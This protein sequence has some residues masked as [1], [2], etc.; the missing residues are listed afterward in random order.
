MVKIKNIYGDVCTGRKD[1]AVYQ[2][3]YGQAMRRVY[4]DNKPPASPLQ[5][6]QR[7]KFK[8]G[9]AYA[10]SLNKAERD[11]I[12][13]YMKEKNIGWKD[14]DPIHWYN[15]AKSIAMKQPEY[16]VLDSVTGRYRFSHPAILK[17]EELDIDGNVL[18]SMDDL[19]NIMDGRFQ[20]QWMQT[21]A[22]GAALVR[23]TTLAGQAYEYTLEVV[24][25]IIITF[26]CPG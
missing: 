1:N 10:E 26:P 3:K 12:K 20:E 25:T 21:P 8:E 5:E 7:D 4:N 16:R 6:A 22:S 11:A 14:G 19:S 13:A 2:R 9:I 15:W 18:F 17:I 24:T 23:A